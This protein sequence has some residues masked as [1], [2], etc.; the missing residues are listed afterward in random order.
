MIVVLIILTI[1]DG[2]DSDVEQ[3]EKKI[4]SSRQLSILSRGA[5][6]IDISHSVAKV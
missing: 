5:I 4:G 6:L 3:L 1:L 2:G